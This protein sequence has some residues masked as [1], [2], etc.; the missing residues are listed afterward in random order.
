[1]MLPQSADA[2]KG[3][4][5]AMLQGRR[6][7]IEDILSRMVEGYFFTAS[8]DRIGDAI[9]ELYRAGQPVD[10]V[11]VGQ[12]LRDRGIL[13]EC[14]GAYYLAELFTAGGVPSNWPAYLEILRE[15]FILRRIIKDCDDMKAKAFEEVPS[16]LDLV[17][18]HSTRALEVGNLHAGSNALSEVSKAEVIELIS[19]IEERYHTRGQ[20]GG[21]STGFV[22]LDRMTDGLKGKQLWVIAGFTGSGKSALAGNIA[23]NIAVEAI[24]KTNRPVAFF[25]MEM[26]REDLIER[27]IFAQARIN[28]GRVRDGLLSAAGFDQLKVAAKK[29]IEGQLMIDDTPGLTI[30]QFRA[31]ARKAV[32]KHGVS[33]LVVDYVQIM[34]GTSRKGG[35]DNRALEIMEI[36]QG[37]RETSKQL[38]V[39]VLALAQLNR[40]MLDR[41]GGKPTLADLKESA[42]IAEEAN[43]VGLLW[44]PSYVVR[45]KTKREEMADRYGVAVEDLD[46]VMELDIVKQRKGPRGSVVLRFLREFTRFESTTEKYLSNNSAHHQR[47]LDEE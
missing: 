46:L 6:D 32:V 8:H 16:V 23:T 33:L 3:V 5:C 17:E 9:A 45:D 38:N 44:Q 14:G 18:E 12:K 4:L 22:D 31:Q 7:T 13:E 2:E 10:T 20:I 24:N 1:M 29:V 35:N 47:D 25:S 40:Q 37:L 39:P 28:L 41:P 26:P 36:M 21:L 30:A 15:K 34:R 27:A 42:A 19:M 43:L 11:T